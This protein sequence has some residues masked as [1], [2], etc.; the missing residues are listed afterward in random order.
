MEYKKQGNELIWRRKGGTHIAYGD[1]FFLV[2]RGKREFIFTGERKKV[3]VTLSFGGGGGGTK[4]FVQK[5]WGGRG[6]GE[7]KLRGGKR[8]DGHL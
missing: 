2:A 6:E 3:G 4:P 8:R 1:S 7:K 5:N